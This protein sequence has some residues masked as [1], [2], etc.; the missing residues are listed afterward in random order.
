MKVWIDEHLSRQLAPWLTAEFGVD[1]VHVSALGL[2][3][4]SDSEIFQQ[5]RAA[6]AVLLTKDFD[7]VALVERW[8]RRRASSG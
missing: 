6:G 3:A 7:F 2:S 1:A 4:V 8:A 5:A